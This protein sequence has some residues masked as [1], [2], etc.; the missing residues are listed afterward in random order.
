MLVRD[1]ELI[2][3]KIIK[4]IEENNFSLALETIDKQDKQLNDDIDFLKVKAVVK[5][6]MHE[7]NQAIN[8]LNQA[9]SIN[10]DD[11]EVYYYLSYAY[12]AL[13]NTQNDTY[14]NIIEVDTSD[15]KIMDN[16][17]DKN[18][19]E[20][21][22][23]A[24]EL[25][26]EKNAPLVSIYVLAYNN[27][28]NATKPCIECILKYTV[29]IDYELILVD[30]G[31]TDATFEYFKS[32]PY[33]RKT[34]IRVS[35][36]VGA[37]YGANIGNKYINGKY[38]VSLPNDILVTKDWLRNMLICMESD[39]S[40]GMVVPKS[41]NTSNLQDPGLKY[42]DFNDMQEKAAQFNISDP[43]KWEERI[44]LITI[45]ALCRKECID[46]AGFFD[47]GFVHNFSDDDVS[48]KFR[49]AGYKLIL[50]GDVFVHHMGSLVTAQKQDV[51]QKNMMAG[52]KTFQKKFFGIDAWDDCGNMEVNLLN[53]VHIEQDNNSVVS[54][55]GI[56]VKCG[57]PLLGLKNKL[58]L[59]GIYNSNISAF[60]QEAKYWLD[61]ETVCNRDVRIDRIEYLNES[62]YDEKF[63]Y[64]LIGEAIN[65]YRDPYG[66]LR[67]ALWLLKNN[68][69]LLCKL[70][71]TS[72][73]V[74]LVERL[75]GEQ[76]I[77]ENQIVD[78]SFNAIQRFLAKKNYKVINKIEEIHSTDE[79]TILFIK[80]LVQNANLCN[81]IDTTVRNL[82]VRDS[83]LVIGKEK[84]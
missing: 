48:F 73:V 36:N 3:K 69:Q 37:M 21:R 79:Q 50:C 10:P 59:N 29:D 55:L 12:E 26:L 34:I 49:R 81:D 70:S 24:Q 74:S 38:V 58:R 77:N 22:A 39:P 4:L 66:I 11:S 57:S 9:K 28:E 46:I 61:L 2:I 75:K 76:S 67:Q 52:K 5:I 84:C 32:I 7:Y 17:D 82:F 54:I 31:S 25:L 71:N 72:D 1:K 15:K 23:L 65:T 43:S 18:I 41:D 63:D 33:H 16:I 42:S 47:Y 45:A 51:Y 80:N 20:V 53:L 83:M 64:I 78:I 68:G 27:L 60:S 40:I 19:I 62:F 13:N 56:D 44:R 30:N 8:I 6:N 14:N 35:D